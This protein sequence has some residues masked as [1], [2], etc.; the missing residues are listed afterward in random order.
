M[1]LLINTAIQAILTNPLAQG[2]ILSQLKAF[3]QGL[4][5]KVDDDGLAKQNEAWLH[6]TLLVLTFLTSAVSLALEGKL[7]SLD[8]SAALTLLLAT[9]TQMYIAAQA[10][11]ATGSKI[12]TNLGTKVANVVVKK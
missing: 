6:P 4:L 9:V 10:S 2:M 7:Q 8:V 11:N 1:D 3:I 12:S 5:K